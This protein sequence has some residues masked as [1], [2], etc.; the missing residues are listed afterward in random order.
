MKAKNCLTCNKEFSRNIKYSDLQWSTAK[1]CSPV[2][3]G[4]SK[5]NGK[6]FNCLECGQLFY[7]K[8]QKVFKDAN[9]FCSLPCYW[10]NQ[11]NGT[12]ETKICIYCKKEF[13]VARPVLFARTKY[14]SLKCTGL[15]KRVKIVGYTTQYNKRKLD[16]EWQRIIRERYQFL[17][18]RCGK[19]DERIHAHHVATRAQRPDLRLDPNNGITLCGS[20]HMWVHGNPKISYEKGWLR[21][22]DYDRERIKELV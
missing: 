6:E 14:C 13:V 22:A 1:Y 16:F 21:R 8:Q 2:C 12:P 19:F 11:R 4:K 20:C 18:Q 5:K 10:A 9:K 15:D 7:K 3:L 17:C